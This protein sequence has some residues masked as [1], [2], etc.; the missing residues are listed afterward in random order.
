MHWLLPDVNYSINL[1]VSSRRSAS[2]F[3]LKLEADCDTSGANILIAVR[4]V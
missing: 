1:M 3:R 4:L 2:P